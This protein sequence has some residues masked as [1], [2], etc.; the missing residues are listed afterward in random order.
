MG[1]K[2]GQTSGSS[3]SWEEEIYWTHFQFIHFIQ[4][5]RNDFQQQLELPKTFSNNVKKKLPENVTLKGP[6]GVVWN[7]GITTRDD[8]VYFVDGWQRFVKDHSLK[9]NDF[10]LF[11]YNGESLFEVLIFDG[12]SNCEKAVS[13]FVGKCDNVKAGQRGRKAKDT[14]TSAEEVITASDGGSSE[15]FRRR[16]NIGTPLAV[17]FETT[18]EKTSNAGVESDSPEQFMADAVTKTAPAALPSQ[19]TSKRAAKKPADDVVPPPARKR[20]RPPRAASSSGTGLD[21]VPF[22]SEAFNKELSG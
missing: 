22:N 1:G 9:E 12:E 14:N 13:Y 10:L 6:S 16:N 20:G 17:P 11:K 8:T 18:N 19:R 15:K 7:I 4:F 5:L 2:G 21:L 3:K